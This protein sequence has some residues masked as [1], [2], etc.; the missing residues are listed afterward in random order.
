MREQRAWI[1]Q[2]QVS[3]DELGPPAMNYGQLRRW[4]GFR[5]TEYRY[6]CHVAEFAS[7]LD[8]WF[9]THRAEVRADDERHPP[10]PGTPDA[11]FAAAGY[12]DLVALLGGHTG[13]MEM[14]LTQYGLEINNAFG[15]R[16]PGAVR[17]A[18]NSVDWIRLEDGGVMFGGVAFDMQKSSS[19]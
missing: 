10:E 17:Y 13:L 16:N 2:E 8:V 15:S 3:P 1:D 5:R 14:Y 7:A 11:E 4:E 18:V 9:E 12:P 6:A 19:G